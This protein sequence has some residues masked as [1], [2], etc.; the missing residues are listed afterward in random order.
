MTAKIFSQDVLN[1]NETHL[2]ETIK[3]LYL[4]SAIIFM[5]MISQVFNAVIQGI[6]RFDVY[7]KLTNLNQFLMLIGNAILVKFGYGITILFAWNFSVVTLIAVLYFL[8][9]KKLTPKIKF[10]FNFKSD[11]LKQILSYSSGVI[12]YQLLGNL[13]LLFERSWVFRELGSE[14]LTFYLVPMNFTFYIHGF[15][16]SITLMLFPMASELKDNKEKLLNIY[17]TTSKICLIIIAFLCVS[18]IVGSRLF[19]TNYLGEEFAN[20]SSSV[21]EI[22]FIT[23]SVLALTIVSWQLSE[24]LGFPKYNAWQSFLWLVI[25][26]PL[27]IFLSY[28]YGI[29]GVAVA[30]L[31]GILNFIFAV[32]VIEKKIFGKVMLR[33][34]LNLIGLLSFICL[35]SGG[36]EYIVFA[37]FP[38]NWLTF[39]FGC[40]IGF[41]VYFVLLF[42]FGIISENEKQLFRKFYAR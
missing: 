22:H 26:I 33:F 40:A 14:K 2:F 21:M 35:I 12:A 30:R 9:V 41:V 39:I 20:N 13:L 27:M 11:S 19:L 8:S 16:S 6:Q 4:A 10:N 31:L 24:G 1:I 18:G 3:A 34:W 17:L 37:N 38:T 23:F 7:S 15:I 25:S 29:I 5:T 42:L 36:I 28:D 32:F